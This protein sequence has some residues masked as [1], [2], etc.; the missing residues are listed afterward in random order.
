MVE[1]IKIDVTDFVKKLEKR[2]IPFYPAIMHI[3]LKTLNPKNKEV[4]FEQEKEL[5][6]KTIYHPD[7]DVFFQN[8]VTDCFEEK[9]LTGPEKDELFFA[10]EDRERA[11]FVLCP[12][13]KNGDKIILTVLIKREI[14]PDFEEICRQVCADF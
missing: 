4:L 3:L 14:T 7:F 6:L 11:D 9:R 8:Y 2:R 13:E 10:L 12:F 5:F 1:K